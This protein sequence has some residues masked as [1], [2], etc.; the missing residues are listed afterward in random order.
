M[1]EHILREL[2]KMDLSQGGISIPIQMPLDGQGYF[3]SAVPLCQL[4]IWLQSSV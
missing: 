3:R 2:R 4:P 1:F